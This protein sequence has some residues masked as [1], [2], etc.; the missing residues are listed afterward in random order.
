LKRLRVPK[1]AGDAVTVA[2]FG[3]T[4]LSGLTPL[5]L[6]GT[7]VRDPAGS[8]GVRM[9]LTRAFD[10]C[11]LGFNLNASLNGTVNYDCNLDNSSD[12]TNAVSVVDC[13][14]LGL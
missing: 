11:L 1:R 14:E 5:P 12:A 2:G 3:F 6:S 8:G 7:L 9:G 13:A 4:T 10:R